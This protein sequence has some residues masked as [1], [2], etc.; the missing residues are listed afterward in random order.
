MAGLASSSTLVGMV[1]PGLH[2]IYGERDVEA[3]PQRT[4]ALRYRVVETDERFRTVSMEIEGGGWTGRV[5]AFLRTPPVTQPGMEALCGHFA[6]DTFAGVR[7]L[8][9]GG[10]RGLGELT[11]KLLAAGGAETWITYRNGREDAE[12]VAA[13]I[14][15]S[16]GSCRAVPWD[17]ATDPEPL[18][19]Q[20]GAMPTEVYYFATPAIFRPQA[21]L[22]RADRLREFLRVYVEGFWTL[23][24]AVRAAELTARFFYP[25]TIFVAERPAGM[26]EYSM[27]KAAGEVLCEEINAH[28]APTRVVVTRLPQLATD[29][30]AS[31]TAVETESAVEVMAEVIARMQPERGGAS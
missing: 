11:A 2:S 28:L 21:R 26:T 12:R 25:S 18:L 16:G 17:A 13:E 4:G 8:I 23:V 9:V 7:A 14:G 20:L 6:A 5:E 22:F 3:A 24:E 31:V 30:T 10:S 29:Q 1:C 19:K 15:N 27:A